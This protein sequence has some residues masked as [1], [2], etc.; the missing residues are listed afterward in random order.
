V[1]AAGAEKVKKDT[2]ETGLSECCL[3][4]VLKVLLVKF[5]FLY[6]RSPFTGFRPLQQKYLADL[7][8]VA[9][10]LFYSSVFLK[11]GLTPCHGRKALEQADVDNH[12]QGCRLELAK[13]QK[14]L[15]NFT[16]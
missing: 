14:D 5:L 4:R 11:P 6:P 16:G 7:T 1:V 12:R 8:A 9:G 15:K 3:H 10:M 13:Q 2:A